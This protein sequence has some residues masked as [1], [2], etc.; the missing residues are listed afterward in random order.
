MSAFE[1]LFGLAIVL[2]AIAFVWNVWLERRAKRRVGRCA[3]PED[4]GG[5]AK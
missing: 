2:M 5:K 4:S 1:I 3:I